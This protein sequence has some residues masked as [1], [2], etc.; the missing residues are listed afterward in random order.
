M[1]QPLPTRLALL[2]AVTRA[3]VDPVFVLDRDGRYLD[4]FGGS[5]REAYDSL[6]YLVGK[7]LHDIMPPPL[8]DQFLA[9]LRRVIDTHQPY[10][11]EFPLSADNLAGNAHDGP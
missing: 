4:A 1:D 5:D 7:T 6:D 9:D 2:E 10:V 3:L 8:A 11:Y